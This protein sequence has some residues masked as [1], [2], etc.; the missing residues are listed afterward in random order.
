MVGRGVI[1]AAGDKFFLNAIRIVGFGVIPISRS[2]FSDAPMHNLTPLNPV[3]VQS[4]LDQLAG[5]GGSRNRPAFFP[6]TRRQP[7]G[8]WDGA[9]ATSY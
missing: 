9:R 4:D 6:S 1:G 3:T 5:P 8:A 7:Q 2:L